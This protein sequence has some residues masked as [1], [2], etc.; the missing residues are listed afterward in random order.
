MSPYRRIA[1]PTSRLILVA[2][3]L[4]VQHAEVDG[5]EHFA[6]RLDADVPPDWPPPLSDESSMHWVLD[7]LRAHPSDEGWT[8]WYFLLSRPGARAIVIGNGGFTGAPSEDGTVEVGYSIVETHQR[9]GYA[10]EAVRGLT[11]WAFAHANVKRLIAHTL[12]ELRPSI[13][14]LEKCGFTFVGD[15]TEAGTI[16]F[17]LLPPR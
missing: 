14:V 7:Y 13:R 12:P 11:A 17:E 5:R 1:V 4:D 6:A 8:K 9:Q 2:V 15:G 3:T 10:P 16:R